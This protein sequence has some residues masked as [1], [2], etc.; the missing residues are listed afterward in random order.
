VQSL[1][2]RRQFSKNMRQ[3]AAEI[4][5]PIRAFTESPGGFDGQYR[6]QIAWVRCYICATDRLLEQQHGIRS[7]TAGSTRSH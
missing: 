1:A 3:W 4:G 5:L 6:C 2:T 7:R